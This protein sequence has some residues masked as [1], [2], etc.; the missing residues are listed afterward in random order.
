LF[1]D[2]APLATQVLEQA[3]RKRI[4]AQ[5]EPDGR[6]PLELARTNLA[7]YSFGEKKWDAQQIGA[8]N[9]QALHGVLRRA[10]SRYDAAQIQAWARR[11]P[12]LNATDRG[13]IVPR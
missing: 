12:P 6:Q 9:P 13:S 1:L 3:K 8:F 2:R 11:L 7:P 5:I 10:A 4:A